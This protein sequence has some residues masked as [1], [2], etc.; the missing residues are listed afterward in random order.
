MQ[1]DPLSWQYC[2]ERD[3]I[4][5]RA[6]HY[7]QGLT[8]CHFEIH[9]QFTPE[10]E[11]NAFLK[12]AILREMPDRV[13]ELSELRDLIAKLNIGMV[14]NV[15]MNFRSQGPDYLTELVSEGFIALTNCI[16]RFDLSFNCRFV[17]F[18]FKSIRRKV[19]QYYD[20]HKNKIQASPY[21]FD[22]I[23]VED[24]TA[25]DI[26]AKEDAK[27]FLHELAR[28]LTASERQTLFAHYGV[29]PRDP[30]HSR[31]QLDKERKHAFRIIRKLQVHIRNN[32]IENSA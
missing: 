16:D 2:E 28:V 1:D 20:K 15:A 25:L 8:Y 10:A 19:W 32:L 6:S 13:N 22:T 3:S 31:A 26:I 5:N 14:I 24:T 27:R 29:I 18:A 7:L 21:E 30:T 12:L 4:P 17:T 9:R 23:G 11:K